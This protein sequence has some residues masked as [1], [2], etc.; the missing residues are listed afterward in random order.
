MDKT[1]TSTKGVFKVTEINAK[2]GFTE[3]EVFTLQLMEKLF[4]II[5]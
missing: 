3:D 2:E 1:G 4:Q 5:L